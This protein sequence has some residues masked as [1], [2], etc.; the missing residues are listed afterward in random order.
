MAHN[1]AVINSAYLAAQREVDTK[2]AYSNPYAMP[3]ALRAISTASERLGAAAST[4]DVVDAAF[5]GRLR[6]TVRKILRQRKAL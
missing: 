5:S 6:G 4:A 1:V 3:I 2:L